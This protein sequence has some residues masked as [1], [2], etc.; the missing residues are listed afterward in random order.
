MPQSG[1]PHQAAVGQDLPDSGSGRFST[2]QEGIDGGAEQMG[3]IRFTVGTN[4]QLNVVR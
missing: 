3:F 4:N 2:D 1:R